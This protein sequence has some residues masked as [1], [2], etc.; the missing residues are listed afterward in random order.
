MRQIRQ[1]SKHHGTTLD[2]S[3]QFSLQ[4]F[5]AATAYLNEHTI[6]QCMNAVSG[7]TKERKKGNEEQS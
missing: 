5:D 7:N 1:K 2:T 4:Q 6:R 3:R